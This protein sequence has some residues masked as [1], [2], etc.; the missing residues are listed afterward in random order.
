M[1]K[2]L[3]IEDHEDV[4]E[5]TAELLELSGYEVETA[6]NGKIG[7]QKAIN[8]EFDLIICDIMMPEFDGYGVLRILSK[9]P[10]TS[11][12]PFIFLTAKSEK[13]DFRKAMQIGADDYITKPFDGGELVEAI[14]TRLRK[15]KLL[16]QNLVENT[17]GSAKTFIDEAKGLRE[18]LELS[19]EREERHYRKKDVLFVAGQIPRHVFQITKG[20]V[21]I[22]RTNAE[23]REFIVGLVGDG[24]FFGY[25]PVLQQ[26][27]Y[28]ASA[29]A[30]TDTEVILIPKDDFFRLI[31]QDRDVAGRFIKLIA[32]GIIETEEKLINLAYDSVRKRVANALISLK[33]RYDQGDAEVFTIAILREDL[34]QIVGTAKETVIRMLSDF[35]DEKLIEIKGSKITLINEKVLR[36]MWQ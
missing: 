16:N 25:L 11:L 34:A 10:K 14:E 17:R 23:G 7:I 26:T 3:I 13:Q 19:E 21:K 5:N 8:G 12:I 28:S 4:R 20:K 18:L 2:I 33:D 22:Y 35:K 32:R 6:E 15:N 36:E 27:T 30:M 9:N 1:T 31:C 24:D 29:V